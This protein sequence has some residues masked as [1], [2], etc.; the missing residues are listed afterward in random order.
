MV[1]SIIKYIPDF[2]SANFWLTKKGFLGA[3]L[4]GLVIAV[5]LIYFGC[6]PTKTVEPGET[7]IPLWNIYTVFGSLVIAVFLWS[8]WRQIYLRTGKG[9]KIG[10]AY[11]GFAVNHKEWNRTRHTLKEL[12]KN[13]HIKGFVS[14]R[15]VP[16][17]IAKLD[18]KSQKYR[19]SYGFR[20]VV[21]IKQSPSINPNMNKE[22]HTFF[23]QVSIHLS[24]CAK[25]EFLGTTFK[26]TANIILERSKTVNNLM[27]V[28]DSR[29]QNIH[30]MILLIAA[31]LFYQEK[32]YQDAAAVACHIDKS[33]EGVISKSKT[34]RLEIRALDMKSRIS[35][36]C[37][38]VS[39]MPSPDELKEIRKFAET[40][41]DYFDEFPDVPIAVSRIRFLT[42]DR[43]GA[44]ELT[45]RYGKKIEE[46][47]SQNITV[48][49]HAVVGYHF[50]FAFISFIQGHWSNAFKSYIDMLNIPEYRNENWTEVINFIDYVA[51]L[52]QYEGISCLQSFY[53]LISG[54]KV[55]KKLKEKALEWIRQDGSRSQFETLLNRS[56]PTINNTPKLPQ[57]KRPKNIKKQKGKRK[58]KRRR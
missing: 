31:T 11:D 12:F 16:V 20:I 43:D 30:D 27:D 58:I 7:N 35:P 5:G 50:N 23:P 46:L 32:K 15:F 28:L 36:V 47:K 18:Q 56:Y 39:E 13:N 19:K 38:S 22:L 55:P 40:A 3:I 6:I 42:G 33:L 52:D 48:P 54:H 26:H 29:A 34:P 2:H 9:L 21:I 1:T 45:Q 4:I 51:D 41:L 8:I 37:F 24:R 49:K 25:T 17:D 57:K 53:R 10:V 44:I 14:L